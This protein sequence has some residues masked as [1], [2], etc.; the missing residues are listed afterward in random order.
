MLKKTGLCNHKHLTTYATHL[1]LPTSPTF[2]NS[3]KVRLWGA[4]RMKRNS[5]MSHSTSLIRDTGENG[6]CA[7]HPPCMEPRARLP[8]GN[9][10]NQGTLHGTFAV[11]TQ[12]P[13]P[14]AA[15]APASTVAAGQQSR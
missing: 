11:E 14:W 5:H 2:L 13:Y 3:S 1:H 7:S 15:T 12:E 4:A 10:K 9:V 6:C 8:V